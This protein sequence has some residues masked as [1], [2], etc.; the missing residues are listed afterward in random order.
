MKKLLKLLPFVLIATLVSC[1][2]SEEAGEVGDGIAVEVTSVVVQNSAGVVVPNAMT[3]GCGEELSVELALTPADATIAS[4]KWSA[5]GGYLSFSSTSKTKTTIT[6]PKSDCVDS[7]TCTVTDTMGN[8]EEYTIEFIAVE[9][10]VAL[11]IAQLNAYNEPL[12][13]VYSDKEYSFN[14]EVTPDGYE[15]LDYLEVELSYAEYADAA[16]T[17]KL[18]EGTLVKDDSF[19]WESGV[20]RAATGE[21]GWVVISAKIYNTFTQ[22]TY[23]DATLE[24]QVVLGASVEDDKPS[25]GTTV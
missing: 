17:T 15:A 5:D 7:V 22:T 19:S 1:S 11:E 8:V 14:L 13:Y 2:T 25:S 24:V 23:S 16:Q 6:A 18:E 9:A 4:I 21:V 12:S 3:L 20:F 10:T